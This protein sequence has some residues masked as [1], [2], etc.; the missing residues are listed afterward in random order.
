MGRLL[1]LTPHTAPPGTVT[2]AA[3]SHVCTSNCVMPYWVKVIT[4][5]GS[6]GAARLSCKVKTSISLM[7]LAPLKATSTQSG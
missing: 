6:A 7:V 4:S 1:R 2:H 5:V 3:P